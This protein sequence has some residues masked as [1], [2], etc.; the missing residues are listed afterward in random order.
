MTGLSVKAVLTERGHRWGR[1][2]DTPSGAGRG[3]SKG[4]EVSERN[5]GY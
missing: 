1:V 2:L 5:A 4:L 3:E